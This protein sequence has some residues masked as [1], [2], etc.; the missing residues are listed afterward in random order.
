[1]PGLPPDVVR[2]SLRPAARWLL[3]PR[4][5]W[6]QSRARFDLATRVPT[7]PRGTAVSAGA[8]GG[9][10]GLE[11]IPPQADRDRVLL[12]FHGGGYCT[13]SPTSH[14]AFVARIAAAA[15]VRGVIPDYRMGDENPYPAAVEDA[16]AVYGQLR[17]DGVAPGDILVAGDSAGGGL[18]LALMLA[19]RD[20]GDPLPAAVGLICPWVDLTRAGNAARPSAPREPLLSKLRLQRFADD[21]LAGA[22][23]AQPRVSPLLADLTGLPPIVVHWAGDDLLAPDGR[24]IAERARAAGVEV[25]ERGF[26]G[27]W[28]DFHLMA[29]LLAGEAS[30][31]LPAMGASLRRHLPARG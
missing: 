31:A 28:H 10:P 11:V 3:S 8:W 21:Y 13:G 30:E 4:A 19:L 5:G 17:A 24:A 25:Q 18:A 26:D 9:V 23:P 7:V 15:G 14:R 29:P 2:A 27:L 1:V 12:F 20:S 22:D 16:V 6:P